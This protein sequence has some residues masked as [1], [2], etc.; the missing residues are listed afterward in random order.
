MEIE[1]VRQKNPLDWSRYYDVFCVCFLLLVLKLK[2]GLL[3]NFTQ[4]G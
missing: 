4:S 3:I 2:L 1:L